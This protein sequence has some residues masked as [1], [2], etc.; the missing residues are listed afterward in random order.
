M[1]E[2]KEIRDTIRESDSYWHISEN[3][4]NG[5]TI[6]KTG[7]FNYNTGN[8]D[9]GTMNY[10]LLPLKPDTDYTFLGNFYVLYPDDLIYNKSN[11][12][13]GELSTLL[14]LGLSNG[15]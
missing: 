7:R 4:W 1:D 8:I 6:Y 9:E 2:F 13:S 14:I 15:F 3:L 10:V 5:K 12:H 11:Y